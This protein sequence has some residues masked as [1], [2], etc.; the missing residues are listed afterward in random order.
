MQYSY[1]F[2][3][4]DPD[5]SDIPYNLAIA[6]S[7]V[8]EESDEEYEWSSLSV[9]VPEILQ[10]LSPLPSGEAVSCVYEYDEEGVPRLS[11]VGRYQDDSVL[12]QIYLSPELPTEDWS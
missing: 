3:K 5:L 12:L 2:P 8:S 7:P 11:I 1:G 6:L 10:L 4:T 9:S